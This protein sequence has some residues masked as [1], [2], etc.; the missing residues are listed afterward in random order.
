MYA[1]SP[2]FR[3]WHSSASA[4]LDGVDTRHLQAGENLDDPSRPASDLGD[5]RAL[6]LVQADEPGHRVLEM[7]DGPVVAG[8]VG[9][10]CPLVAEIRDRALRQIPTAHAV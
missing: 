1:S 10:P 8:V 7:G 2:A 6:E 5:A 3:M 9:I 4:R